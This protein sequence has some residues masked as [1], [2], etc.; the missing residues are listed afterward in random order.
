VNDV[1][2]LI[3]VGN[4]AVNGTGN[5]LDNVI[6]G[7]SAANTLLGGSG[8][9]VLDGGAG[10]DIVEGNVGNDTLDGGA[11]SDTMRG[12]AGDDSYFVDASDTVVENAGEGI[13]T[14]NAGFSYTLG[15]NLENLTLTGAGSINGTGNALDNVL[16]GGAGANVLDG[17]AGADTMIGGGGADTYIVD[18]VGDIVIEGPGAGLPGDTVRSSISYVLPDN[19]ENLVLTGTGA[20]NGTGNALA[21]SITGNSA[22]NVLDGGGNAS[23]GLEILAGGAGDDTYVVYTSTDIQVENPDEGTDT[24]YS[25]S[26]FTILRENV[27]N[28][29]MLVSGTGSGSS[30]DN[31][32]SGTAGNDFLIG[33][34]GNDLLLG[35]AGNDTLTGGDGNDV[36]DGGTGVDTMFGGAGNDQFLV[37]DAADQTIENSGEGTDTVISAVS[38]T[39]GANVENL[40]LTGATAIDGTG[41][42]LDNVVTGNS[43]ANVL[44]GLQGNDTLIGGAGDDTYYVGYPDTVNIVENAGEGTDTVNVIAFGGYLLDANVERLL[45]IMGDAATGNALNNE[46]YGNG[47]ANFLD[48]GAGA[49]LLVGGLDNDTYVV[50]NAGDTVVELAGEGYDIVRSSVSYTLGATL[51]ELQLTGNAAINGTGND[52]NNSIY[53]N[54]A[55]NV[56][57]GG[58]G[59]D[60]LSGGFGIDTMVGGVGDDTY[61][62]FDT[63]DVVVENAGEGVDL[64]LASSSYTLSANVENM[65]LNFSGLTGTG[66]ALDNQLS[67]FNG[68]NTLIGAGGNDT[69]NSFGSGDTLIGGTGN[70]LYWITA[71]N[72]AIV[73]NANEGN[74]FVSSW[75]SYTLGA[76]LESL[77]LLGTEVINGTGNALANTIYG[78]SAGNVLDGGAGADSMSGLAGDDTYVVDNAGDTVSEFDA[79]GSDTVLASVSYTLGANVENL[80]LTGA[81]SINGTGNALDNVLTGNSANNTLAGGAGNDVYFVQNTG[82]VVNE[83]AGEGTDV[84]NTSLTTTLGANL[85]GLFLTGTG[86]I[87]G[88]GNSLANLVRGNT[89]SNTLNGGGGFDALEGGGGIDT[90]TDTTG[91]NYFNGGAGNDSI[92]GGAGRDFFMGGT[93]NDTIGTGNGADVIVFNVGDGQDTVNPSSGVDDTLSLGGTGLTYANL[94]FQKV[95]KDLVLNVSAT[96]KVTFNNWY[97]GNNNKNLLNLQVIAE[98]MSA[99]D[100]GSS[101]PLLDQ[102]VETFDFQGLVDAFDTARAANPGLTTWALSNALNQEHL[103]GSDF[104]TLGGDLAYFYGRDGTLAGVSFDAAQSVITAQNFGTQAQLHLIGDPN[105]GTM[106]LS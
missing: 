17:G 2:N 8:N 89:A 87:N 35:N 71:S 48:G 91:G 102:K 65:Q 100:P 79:Q 68:G 69:L 61:D 88:T 16:T 53:G 18:N 92:T 82:D 11:G 33:N 99:F 90:L 10:N 60:Y 76:N 86:S 58:L 96:D 106:K 15:A 57:N 24:V 56:L 101:D 1:E 45:L 97:Q 22:A 77:Q 25:H 59:N 9:D 43:A 98:A 93:G 31:T 84:V 46:I 13:D 34:G 95:G 32:I 14:V 47:E 20:I 44:N 105:Q 36:L 42:E 37:D 52:G 67:S 94:T 74:D 29:V 3:L 85:E 21:N 75:A 54:S 41:N 66:N 78:N 83:N 70:D 5:L 55:A 72:T 23:G 64:V 38:W 28:L 63:G 40:V 6:I 73:E 39:L 4:A 62:V 80:T 27:E 81:G 49:D 12:G 7:N 19:V 26:A 51:E 50:D 30:G 104:E 103:G